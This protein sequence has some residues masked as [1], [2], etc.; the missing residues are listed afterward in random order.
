MFIRVGILLRIHDISVE[1]VLP[2]TENSQK[3]DLHYVF[4][5]DLMMQRDGILIHL[6]YARACFLK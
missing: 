3:S 4:N 5:R 2:C 6:R 1:C